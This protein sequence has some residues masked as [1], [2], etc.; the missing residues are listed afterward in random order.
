MTNQDSDTPYLPK[1]ELSTSF[2]FS[3]HHFQINNGHIHIP[4]GFVERV[5]EWCYEYGA[6]DKNQKFHSTFHSE[7]DP[8]K[9]N[10]IWEVIE[11]IAPRSAFVSSWVQVYDRYGWHPSHHH[12]ALGTNRS[13]CLYLTDG[14]STN[15]QN[16]LHLDTFTSNP[17]NAGD[18]LYWDPAIYHFSSPAEEDKRTI[19]AFNLK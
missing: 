17:V 12:H 4:E 2:L 16:P 19:L 6:Y 15:F 5:R 1:I 11:D 18:V 14:K 9:V 3:P 13:G 8:H 10:W 7:Y